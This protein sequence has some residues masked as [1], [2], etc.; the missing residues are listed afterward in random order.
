MFGARESQQLV[1]V[2]IQERSVIDDRH[3]TPNTTFALKWTRASQSGSVGRTDR[4]GSCMD[5]KTSAR[6]LRS[7]RSLRR[8]PTCLFLILIP[9]TLGLPSSSAQ[10]QTCTQFL[11]GPTD[12]MGCWSDVLSNAD[13]WP[14]VAIHSNLLPD[15]RIISWGRIEEAAA[16]NATIWDWNTP[17]NF[18]VSNSAAFKEVYF[19]ATTYDTG[20][21]TNPPNIDT[22]PSSPRRS[23]SAST[24]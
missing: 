15:G 3:A 9:L 19:P 24:G 21:S 17:W 11:N 1:I 4:Q 23:A 5:K 20:G 14:L 10:A 18:G 6:D 16:D 12:T 22:R 2:V 7:L 8:T 13:G